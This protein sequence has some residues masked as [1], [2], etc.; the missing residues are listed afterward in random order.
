MKSIRLWV[1][2]LIAPLVVLAQQAIAYALV[3][4][5]CERQ[6]HWTIHVVMGTSCAAVLLMTVM[7][8][9]AWR[10][11]VANPPID[12][13]EASRT[14]FLSIV[15]VATSALMMLTIAAQWLTT[16]FVPPCVH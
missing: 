1:P 3:P 10:T 14:R 7:A 2:I 6:Q 8:W 4:L 12:D 15:A 11:S 16:A 5:A 9:G 13:M